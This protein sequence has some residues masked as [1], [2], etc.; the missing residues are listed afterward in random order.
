MNENSDQQ[1]VPGLFVTSAGQANVDPS[2]TH[3]LFDLAGQ[4]EGPTHLPVDVEHVLAAVV[5]AVRAG[6]IDSKTPLSAED[7]AVVAMLVDH[8]KTV[9]ERFGGNV[10]RDDNTD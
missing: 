7:P 1:I 3:V 10:G 2:L 8:V 4:L 6:E 5:L 9:F